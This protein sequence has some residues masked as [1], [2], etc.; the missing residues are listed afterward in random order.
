MLLGDYKRVDKH[1]S[2]KNTILNAINTCDFEKMREISNFFYKTSG[3]Y[4]R[5]CRYMA[6]LYRYDWLVTP[7][8]GEETAKTEDKVLEKFYE[9]LLYLDNFEIK[10]F[11]GEV[12]LK[13]IRN[14][15]YY[16][17]LIPPNKKMMR[18]LPSL[19]HYARKP[20]FYCRKTPKTWHREKPTA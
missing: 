8:I 19:T 13:V 11:F 20:H 10:R 3:I 2:D 5:L 17:Y 18:S 6:Y 1:L 16:G 14:G 4:S 12:A 9:I 7:Y 15:C